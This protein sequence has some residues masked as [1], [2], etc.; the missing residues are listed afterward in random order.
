VLVSVLA[1]FAHREAGAQT[2]I[3][4]L[5]GMLAGMAGF[6]AFCETIA[7]AV[8]YL[9]LWVAFLAATAAAVLA[10]L[11]VILPYLAAS[12]GRT[13]ARAGNPAAGTWP[14]VS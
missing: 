6:V 5:R 14:E 12:A 13:R 9:G 11:L 2:L 4:L 7:V 3:A 10:Q 8:G 1:V